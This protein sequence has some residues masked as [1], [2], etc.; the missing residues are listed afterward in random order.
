MIGRST[1]TIT[2]CRFAG[3]ARNL[4]TFQYLYGLRIQFIRRGAIY[5]DPKGGN[6]R[7]WTDIA[8]APGAD[9]HH[10]HGSDSF[11]YIGGGF[12]PGNRLGRIPVRIAAGVMM[13]PGT[14]E[15]I[16]RVTIGPQF[17]FS[18]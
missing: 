9:Y 6:L 13:L 17:Q 2:R 5:I 1:S 11:F 7:R 18:K 8:T 3:A 4:W 14:G 16:F 10:F 12:Q 15:K